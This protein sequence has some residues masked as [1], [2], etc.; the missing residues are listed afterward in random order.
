MN[1]L[2]IALALSISCC[3]LYAGGAE[4]RQADEHSEGNSLKKAR[5]Q[6]ELEK[7]LAE[8]LKGWDPK[9]LMAP[10]EALEE[11]QKNAEK[12]LSDLKSRGSTSSAIAS[13][14]LPVA[15]PTVVS[16]AATKSPTPPSPKSAQPAL[17][18]VGRAKPQEDDPAS[19]KI[20][21]IKPV[22]SASSKPAAAAKEGAVNSLAASKP[23]AIIL[24]DSSVSPQVKQPSAPSLPTQE[25]PKAPELTSV[26]APL[27][28]HLAAK[29]PESVQ[30]APSTAEK[31]QSLLNSAASIAIP[32][33][34][35]LDSTLSGEQP[36]N[37]LLTPRKI[38]L[39]Q[40]LAALKSPAIQRTSHSSI[41]CI[42]YSTL[43]KELIVGYLDCSIQKYSQLS[44]LS[45]SKLGDHDTS[46][47][48]MIVDP[49]SQKYLISGSFDGAIKVWNIVERRC[50]ASWFGHNHALLSLFI[51]PDNPNILISS[52][53]DGT[54]K[55]WNLENIHQAGELKVECPADKIVCCGELK[56]NE[57]V[58]ALTFL[59]GEPNVALIGNGTEIALYD[60]SNTSKAYSWDNS[61][62]FNAP[63]AALCLHP[64]NNDYIIVGT[65][66][67]ALFIWNLA[68]SSEEFRLVTQL[69][70]SI[71]TSSLSKLSVDFYGNQLVVQAGD[72]IALWNLANGRFITSMKA[73]GTIVSFLID[74]TKIIIAT[75]AGHLFTADVIRNQG[76]I[77]SFG[78]LTAL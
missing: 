34:L 32:R 76:E 5:T 33:H 74:Q 24:N 16:R 44:P 52:S 47:K 51:N 36:K 59:P 67:G 21:V 42:A 62:L 56:F 31:V 25:V 12:I 26:P 8:Q 1:K 46:V 43:T 17:K 63:I 10:L 38:S 72:T 64:K 55:L 7:L 65:R 75:V 66:S 4:K 9:E 61:S 18:P 20:R 41:S 15:P 30:S 27:Q 68:A 58:K 70:G 14:V 78:S 40:K 3:A 53:E 22:T 23:A 50:I 48:C 77:T 19:T 6:D 37:E 39:L 54:V 69:K 28:E 35:S 45:G 60:L 13:P 2:L 73:P 11:R 29:A 49:V 57:P 71:D